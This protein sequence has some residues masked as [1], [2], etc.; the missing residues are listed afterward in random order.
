MLPQIL[1]LEED[2]FYKS[3]KQSCKIR[4]KQ[5]GLIIGNAVIKCTKNLQWSTFPNCTCPQPGLSDL[6]KEVENC[7]Q[8]MPKESCKLKCKKGWRFSGKD[9]LICDNN[10]KWSSQ[11]Q[12][13]KAL[14]P[15]LVLPD[16]PLVL[17]EVC[18]TRTIGDT[19]QMAC[20]NRGIII[21]EDKMKCSENLMWS[22]PP[23]CTC[24]IPNFEKSTEP[25]QINNSEW[26][27]FPKCIKK[28]CP[29]PKLLDTYLKLI[30]TCS[31]KYFEDICALKCK[32]GGEIIGNNT[33]QCQSNSQWSIQPNCT[34]PPLHLSSG[35]KFKHSCGYIKPEEKCFLQC[36]ED[37][38]LIGKSFVSCQ[39]NTKWSSI[40]KCIHK[41]CPPP[42]LTE[43]IEIKKNCSFK[44][45]GERC[46]VACK[47]GGK[48]DASNEIECLPTNTWSSLPDCLCPAPNITQ[49]LLILRGDCNFKKRNETCDVAC[50]QGYA[51]KTKDVIVCLPNATWSSLPLCVKTHCSRPVLNKEILKEGENCTFKK[52]KET[53]RV[54][55]AQGG[56]LLGSNIIKCLIEVAGVFP[57]VAPVQA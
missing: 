2:C 56:R 20:K 39:I 47:H 32:E 42:N 43:Y 52:I 1:V 25:I 51:T 21:G 6:V 57:Q 40:P 3:V 17:K 46:E 35:L 44:K 38:E 19:C 33:F 16:G 9:F 36:K 26:S 30:E 18:F 7:S 37:M 15:D 55:C 22:E 45:I 13:I 24:P 54:H 10:T 14:C 29:N 4:C 34:C 8:K 12:C 31:D 11:P 23:Q 53:C 28:S 41:I 27:S 50:P 48:I 5:G 49:S